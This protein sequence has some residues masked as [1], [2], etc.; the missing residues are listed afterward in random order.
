[1]QTTL[2]PTQSGLITGWGVTVRI[3]WVVLYTYIQDAF[4]TAHSV[5]STVDAH[6]LG[7]SARWGST[8]TCPAGIA[9]TKLTG[10]NHT[11]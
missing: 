4:G 2:G 6:I 8:V 10:G 5:H 3:S 1:M 11:R 9:Y 7:V